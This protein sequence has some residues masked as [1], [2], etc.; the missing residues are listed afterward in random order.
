MKLIF[1]LPYDTKFKY[2]SLIRIHVKQNY[3]ETKKIHEWINI[4]Q[5]VGKRE[6]AYKSRYKA[7]KV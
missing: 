4:H 1:N 7:I 2:L 6:Q 3:A 5:M